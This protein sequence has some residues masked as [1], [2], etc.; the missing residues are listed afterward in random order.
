VSRKV[1]PVKLRDGSIVNLL[2]LNCLEYFD[3]QDRLQPI[4]ADDG[5][6]EKDKVKAGF[7]EKLSACVCDENGDRLLPD[8]STALA[9]MGTVVVGDLYRITE[10]IEANNAINDEALAET[11]KK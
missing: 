7:A 5:R 4:R 2:V 10:Q 8:V 3:L 1:T 11:E 9:Y 6:S